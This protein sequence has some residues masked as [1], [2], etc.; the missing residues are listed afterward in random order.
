MST[1]TVTAEVP[2]AA[3]PDSVTPSLDQLAELEIRNAWDNYK[4]VEKRGL[5]VGRVLYEWREKFSAQGK[6][7]EGLRAMLHKVG[8][9]RRTAYRWIERYKIEIGVRMTG[10]LSER[11]A[12]MRRRWSAGRTT[13]KHRSSPEGLASSAAG[14]KSGQQ[15]GKK[16]LP[17]L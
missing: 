1:A 4:I 12:E 16:K 10:I 14:A 2:A 3:L 7:G 5:E 13:G 8:I 6:K 11:Q 17:L 9:P 15:N